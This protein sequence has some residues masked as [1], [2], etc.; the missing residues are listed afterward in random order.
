MTLP[1]CTLI[2]GCILLIATR[3][4]MSREVQK[5]I[6]IGYNNPLGYGIPHIAKTLRCPDLS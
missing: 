2:P 4:D 5:L 3:Y 1:D 6:I